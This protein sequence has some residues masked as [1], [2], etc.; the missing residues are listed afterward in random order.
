MEQQN[1]NS[2]NASVTQQQNSEE[3]KLDDAGVPESMRFNWYP[4]PEVTITGTMG[5]SLTF[6][7]DN[8]IALKGYWEESRWDV[9]KEL[10]V[11]TQYNLTKGKRYTIKATLRYD[12]LQNIEVISEG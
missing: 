10:S 7:P 11:P 2:T 3:K 12:T 5:S 1:N 9:L 8:P 6:Y 4:N